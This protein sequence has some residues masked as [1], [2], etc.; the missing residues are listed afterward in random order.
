MQKIRYGR[1]VRSIHC[2]FPGCPALFTST[3]KSVRERER[4]RG[5]ERKKEAERERERA[6]TGI[7]CEPRHAR[8]SL[9]W[10]RGV[11]ARVCVR[12]SRIHKRQELL[13]LFLRGACKE[14]CAIL[15]YAKKHMY[16]KTLFRL[17]RLSAPRCITDLRPLGSHTDSAFP[18]QCQIRSSDACRNV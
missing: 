17:L 4:E 9:A 8:S 10:P 2:V 11:K 18:S 6:L 14:L 12:Q 3:S 7:S 1:V 15:F 16:S 13:L 5:R